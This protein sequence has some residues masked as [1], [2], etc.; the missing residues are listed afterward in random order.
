MEFR[1]YQSDLI[2]KSLPLLEKHKFVY[3]AM[4]VRTGKTLTSLGVSA[5]LPVSNLLF[6]TKKKQS[7]VSNLI[8]IC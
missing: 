7:A 6:V 4:E 8:M 1:D 5:L 3:L 2:N